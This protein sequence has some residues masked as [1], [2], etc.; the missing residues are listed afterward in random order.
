MR[1]VREMRSVLAKAGF[2]VV[3]TGTRDIGSRIWRR[4]RPGCQLSALSPL[5]NNLLVGFVDFQRYLRSN[6]FRT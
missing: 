2:D 5:S 4:E 1:F 6:S 3:R